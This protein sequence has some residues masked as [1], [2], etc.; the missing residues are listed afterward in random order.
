MSAESR[1]LG[2]RA[3]KR[4]SGSLASSSGVRRDD[5][6]YVALITMIFCSA[7]TSQPV[8]TNSVASQSNSSGCDG[9][10]PCDPK[11][12]ADFT[13]PVPKYICQNRFTVT[14]AISGY[15]GS[16][17]HR[18]KPRRFGGYAFGDDTNIAG[19]MGV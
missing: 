12:S 3:S 11:S 17:S 19:S 16:T 2:P 1:M 13:I 8:R 9:G 7:L 4:L 10:S 6:L 14:R 5:C 18:A 15:D